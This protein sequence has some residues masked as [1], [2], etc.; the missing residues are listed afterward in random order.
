MYIKQPLFDHIIENSCPA[1]LLSANPSLHDSEYKYFMMSF[2][3]QLLIETYNSKGDTFKYPNIL[4][5]NAYAAGVFT[6][7]L[8]QQMSDTDLYE[9]TQNIIQIITNNV[10]HNEEKLIGLLL[11]SGGEN[12]RKNYISLRDPILENLTYQMHS[13]IRMDGRLDV[14]M[15]T[16]YA[17]FL[18]G[19]YSDISGGT[20]A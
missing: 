11:D 18:L 3:G 1:D 8:M 20:K 15:T 6:R 14:I 17:T 2:C 5:K 4:L 7:F 10:F 12:L 19:V 16:L 9:K 13:E